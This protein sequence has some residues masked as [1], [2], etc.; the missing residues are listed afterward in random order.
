MSSFKMSKMKRFL[1]LPAAIFLVCLS[2]CVVSQRDN[3][4]PGAVTIQGLSFYF[5]MKISNDELV[6]PFQT[7]GEGMANELVKIN[8]E[9]QVLWR[10]GLPKGTINYAKADDK[11]VV[12]SSPEWKGDLSHIKTLHVTLMEIK[13][14]SIV[15]DKDLLTT[16]DRFLLEPHVLKDSLNNFKG[17]L[18]RYSVPESNKFFEKERAMEL[19]TAGS[20]RMEWILLDD[21]L[22]V[23]SHVT[24]NGDFTNAKFLTSYSTAEGDLI[25]YNIVQNKLTA[26]KYTEGKADKVASL[27]ATLSQSSDLTVRGYSLSV[28]PDEKNALCTVCFTPDDKLF[29]VIVTKFDFSQKQ[30]TA[31]VTDQKNKND[32]SKKD[33]GYPFNIIPLDVEYYKNGFI[34]AEQLFTVSHLA[35]GLTSSTEYNTGDVIVSFFDER[36][37]EIKHLTI[38][39]ARPTFFRDRYPP[40]SV[41]I[42]AHPGVKII[43]DKMIILAK[44]IEEPIKEKKKF[45][46]EVQH[47]L[48]Y[49]VIGLDSM[50]IIKDTTAELDN[51]LYPYSYYFSGAEIWMNNA[52]L[53]YHILT[54]PGDKNI[55]FEKTAFN[56]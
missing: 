49:L 29:N 48:R 25:I 50:N 19:R 36:M 42:R 37:Q 26:D 46:P 9:L 3:G 27:S 38:T 51:K 55:M 56:F 54:D 53:L 24:L 30:A 40:Y 12:F 41:N 34:K 23:K 4:L 21:K 16:D 14:G 18:L 31:F 28:S 22:D 35:H 13:D 47:N 7:Y 20:E 52:A 15:L 32:F 44:F 11:I 10:K 39:D 43:G 45:P 1:K 8:T 6:Y 17:L 5:P 2:F 33:W